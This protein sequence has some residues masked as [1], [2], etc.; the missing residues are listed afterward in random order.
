MDGVDIGVDVVVAAAV[1]V[2]AGAA[3]GAVAELTGTA[4]GDDVD[5]GVVVVGAS[6]TVSGSDG[7]A[8]VVAGRVPDPQ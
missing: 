5:G 7:H 4:C 1:A 3:I 6:K 2:A 8:P